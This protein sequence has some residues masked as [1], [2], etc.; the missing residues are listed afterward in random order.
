MMFN[1]EIRA[2]VGRVI[3]EWFDEFTRFRFSDTPYLHDEE[4]L[5][6][7]VWLPTFLPDGFE[8]VEY[9]NLGYGYVVI[10]EFEDGL[11]SRISL[12]RTSTAVDRNV[13]NQQGIYQ[14]I[15]HEGITY[16]AFIAQSAEFGH[17]IVWEQDGFSFSVT[18][19][20]NIDIDKV[21][22]VVFSIERVERIQSGVNEWWDFSDIWLPVHMPEGFVFYDTFT[23]GSMHITDWMHTSGA[24]MWLM[25]T[26]PPLTIDTDNEFRAYIPTTVDGI[27]YHIFYADYTQTD[28]IS[29]VIWEE[30]GFVFLLSIPWFIDFNELLMIVTSVELTY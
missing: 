3:M 6:S 11:G 22:E 10:V 2:Q 26:T 15:I 30:G 18:T 29:T 24:T 1:D 16:H 25:Q 14:V 12:T 5:T 4:T 21:L 8:K 28:D 9:I 19:F 23:A 27:L 20:P 17:I 7:Y 13:S